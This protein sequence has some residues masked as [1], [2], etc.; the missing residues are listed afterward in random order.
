[1][2]RF[3]EQPTLNLTIQLD[4]LLCHKRVGSGEPYL[5][6]I[7]FKADHSCIRI[8]EAFHLEGKPEFRFTEHGTGSLGKNLASRRIPIPA[9]IGTWQTTLEPLRIPYFNQAAI[10]VAGVVY[11]ALDHHNLSNE[12]AVAA[13]K[14]LNEH[15]NKVA[16]RVVS[17][18]DPT[19]I[20]LIRFTK[21][22]S[23]YFGDAF[24]KELAGIENIIVDAVKN[25]QSL[26][27]NIWTL[28]HKDNLVG[29]EFHIFTHFDFEDDPRKPVE[30]SHRFKT[31]YGDW[32]VLGQASVR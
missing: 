30:F 29:Y 1:M 32:E 19:Q 18:F 7:F 28:V 5:W 3:V 20:E 22:I 14:A 15:I 23:S 12:G 10:G 31:E 4:T 9:A 11:I 13:H 2:Q 8:N 24:K 16:Q 21:S 26:V 27:Q 17:G 6:T 25:S